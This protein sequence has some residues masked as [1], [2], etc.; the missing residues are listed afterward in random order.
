MKKKEISKAAASCYPTIITYKRRLIRS[1]D[2]TWVHKATDRKDS[3]KNRVEVIKLEG[4]VN[5]I[6]WNQRWA[7]TLFLFTSPWSQWDCMFCSPECLLWGYAFMLCQPQHGYWGD[8]HRE[9]NRRNPVACLV[10]SKSG[11]SPVPSPDLG[12]LI[13]ELSLAAG[14]AFPSPT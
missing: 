12:L 4:L 5:A 11:A 7:Q 8:I 1:Q 10:P 13:P 3:A 14:G 2:D 9:G 6:N